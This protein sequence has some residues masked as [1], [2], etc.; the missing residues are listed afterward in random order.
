MPP[1]RQGAAGLRL[2][3]RTQ[4]AQ[5]LR[6]E[7]ESAI[8]PC[9]MSICVRYLG[10]HIAFRTGGKK[11]KLI[12]K[13][14]MSVVFVLGIVVCS[15]AA[16]LG[17]NSS[18]EIVQS[19]RSRLFTLDLSSADLELIAA[20]KAVVH[21]ISSSNP[22]EIAGM[23]IILADASPGAFIDSYRTLAVFRNSPRILQLGAFGATP[24]P[25]DL[26][27]LVIDRED[28]N[29]LGKAK[30]GDSEIKLSEAEISRL[31]AVAARA[32]GSVAETRE[33]LSEEYKKIL[34]E[35]AAAYS[36]GGPA[37]M[38][39]YSD[40]ETSINAGE[41]MVALATEES[42]DGRDCEHVRRFLEGSPTGDAADSSFLY[43][44]KERFGELKSVVN[45]LHVYIHKEGDRFFIAS[46][47]VYSNHYTEAALSVAEF[48]PFT[49]SSGQPHTI[50]AYT[51][52]LQTDMLGGSLGFVK[53]HM[54]APRILGTLRESLERLQSTLESPDPRQIDA[55][56]R[57]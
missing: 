34:F 57:N 45:I 25:A 36:K 40:K 15:A 18:A 33:R 10:T 30:A 44:A 29:A 6:A 3:R 23:G 37:G 32:K 14:P 9:P 8:L 41:S 39:G 48:I 13:R 19:L 7:D 43:W 17:G 49:D 53:K 16:S 26:D 4:S 35:R 20:R 55:R 27:G 56:A 47:Q 24:K 12:M 42:R 21:A 28:L 38:P 22:K 51:L 54:A 52:R 1:P 2:P 5:F 50:I 11:G 46:K 31:Q